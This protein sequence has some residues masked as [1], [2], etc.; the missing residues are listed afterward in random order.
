MMKTIDEI[1][2]ILYVKEVL[3][4]IGKKDFRVKDVVKEAYF[5]PQNRMINQVFK[6]LQKNKKQ[7][8][9]VLDEYGGTAGLVTMEDILE[10]LVGDIYDEY[11]EEEKKFEKIDNNTYYLSGNMPIY[12]VNKLLDAGIPEGD[13]DTISGYLQEQL[14]RIQKIQKSQ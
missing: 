1:K 12:D 3:K 13:Y 14:G 2:G 5:V 9:I 10:E 8:A 6:D 11:D 4:N 7:I